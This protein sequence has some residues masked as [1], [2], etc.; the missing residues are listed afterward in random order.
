MEH[1]LTNPI[2]RLFE[3]ISDNPKSLLHGDHTLKVSR[4]YVCAFGTCGTL[5]RML[6]RKLQFTMVHPCLSVLRS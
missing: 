1:Q 2:V 5:P 6:Q 4:V 3:A